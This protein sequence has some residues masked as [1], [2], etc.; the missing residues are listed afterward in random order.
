MMSLNSYTFDELFLPLEKGTSK[1]TS[2]AIYRS[3]DYAGE[4]IPLW[5][6]NSEHKTQSLFVSINAKNKENKPIKVFRGPCLI[7]SLDGSAGSMTFK[8]ENSTF[9]LNHHAGVLRLRD[10]KL[11]DL[12]YFKYRYEG[13]LSALAV[14]DGSKTLSKKILETQIFELPSL[15]EQLSILSKYKKLD[16]IRTGLLKHL[17]SIDK[18][19]LLKLEASDDKTE[20]KTIGD[21]FDLNQG[22]QIT[23]LELYSTEG[24]VPVYTGNNELKGHWDKSIISEKDLPCLSYPTKANPGVVYIQNELFDANNTAVL[25][26]KAEWRDKLVL[27]WFSIK[28][29][30]IFLD[31]MTS[32]EGV[33]YL[34]KDIVEK[35]EIEIPDKKV[36]E[37]EAEYFSKVKSLRDHI[38]PRL[39]KIDTLLGKQVLLK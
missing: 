20:T 15:S 29:P 7:I 23:D 36:Q 2:Y 1:L 17:N 12:E 4:L 6:G 26:P 38:V 5:G 21:I 11:L 31:L 24:D 9:A 39:A 27:E 22:H 19:Q 37:A 32:K 28:L 13:L 16:S 35:I 25:V 18:I 33:S 34:N 14:S 30:P 8:D 10:P 3:L